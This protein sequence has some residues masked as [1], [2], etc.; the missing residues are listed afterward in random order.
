MTKP[1]SEIC[2]VTGKYVDYVVYS[3]GLVNINTNNDCLL[4]VPVDELLQVVHR[5]QQSLHGER[6]ELR[7]RTNT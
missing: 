4:D 1:R 5:Y 7:A 2:T 6:V 3:D